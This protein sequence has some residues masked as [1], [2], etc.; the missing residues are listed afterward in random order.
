[1]VILI[2]AGIGLIVFLMRRRERFVTGSVP[3]N[4]PDGLILVGKKCRGDGADMIDGQCPEGMLMNEEGMCQRLEDPKCPAE[5]TLAYDDVSAMCEPNIRPVELTDEE[6]LARQNAMT[7]PQCPTGFT[8][9]QTTTLDN[10]RCMRDTGQA[11]VC[12]AGSTFDRDA[13]AWSV[14][15]PLGT[16]VCFSANGPVPAKCPTGTYPDFIYL[17]NAEPKFACV[18]YQSGAVPSEPAPPVA[19]P[20]PP[21][22]APPPPPPPTPPIAPPPPPPIPPPTPRELVFQPKL[23]GTPGGDVLPADTR[24]GELI[25]GLFSP[26]EPRPEPRPSEYTL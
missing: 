9:D 24:I 13:Y 3:P 21:P 16:G 15:E 4:C 1:M 19:P 8:R 25:G 26:A 12:P 20:A 2:L 18:E 7:Q 23:L 6:N 14:N 17:E 5:Y 10:L 22:S 11:P